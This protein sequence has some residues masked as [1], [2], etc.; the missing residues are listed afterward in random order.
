MPVGTLIKIDASRNSYQNR[1]QSEL[2]SKRPPVGALIK[3]SRQSELLSK[4]PPVGALIKIDASRSSYQKGRQSELLSNKSRQSELLSKKAAS[5]SSYQKKPPV[6]AL[7]ML[8][9][10]ELNNG[11]TTKNAR[12]NLYIY[13]ALL[14]YCH[15][16]FKVIY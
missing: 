3:K 5:R 10:L 16:S 4:K 11:G 9:K 12:L 14:L 2:L 6:G 8:L 15:I 7:E 1:C 13:I